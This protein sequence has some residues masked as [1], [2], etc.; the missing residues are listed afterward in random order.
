MTR[1]MDRIND[2]LREVI[3]QIISTEL[4]DP[5]INTLVSVTRVETAPDLSRALVHV[6]I[7]G[8]RI[9]KSACIKA[10]RSASGYIRKNLHSTVNLK[11]IPDLNFC[12]DETME[13]GNQVLKLIEKVNPYP[14]DP[15]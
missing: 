2:L 11:T 3:S 10:L 12:L 8:S 5:R 14:K 6:S 9:D 1:R 15:Q 4:S 7:M 13:R